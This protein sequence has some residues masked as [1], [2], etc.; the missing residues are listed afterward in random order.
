M[1]INHT[2][3]I[4]EKRVEGDLLV[5]DIS[6]QF[7]GDITEEVVTT[8]YHFRPEAVEEVES[9]IEGRIITEKDKLLA[10]QKIEEIIT[11]L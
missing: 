1:A 7:T 2:Y 5:T 8:V 10:K 3:T 4:L 9:N 6:I 11:E